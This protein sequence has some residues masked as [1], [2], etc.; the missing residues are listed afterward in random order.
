MSTSKA[1]DAAPGDLPVT[2][3]HAADN[4]VIARRQLVAGGV[5][6]GE[7][8][9]VR[10]LVPPWHPVAARAMA[11]AAQCPSGCGGSRRWES[12]TWAASRPAAPVLTYGT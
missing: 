4:V 11:A 5:L 12:L 3:I 10:G 9:N 1:T 7:G 6:P 2:R 8:V